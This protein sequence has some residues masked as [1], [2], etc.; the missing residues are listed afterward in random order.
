MTFLKIII[1][2]LLKFDLILKLKICLETM[3]LFLKKP[4]MV[5]FLF[6]VGSSDILVDLS[7]AQLT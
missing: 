4:P 7:V 6:Q 3:G 2:A 1:V 5:L